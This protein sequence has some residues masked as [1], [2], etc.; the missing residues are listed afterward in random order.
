MTRPLKL[1]FLAA[2]LMTACGLRLPPVHSTQPTAIHGTLYGSANEGST[3]DLLP[4][5]NAPLSPTNPSLASAPL[6]PD[7]SFVLTLPSPTTLAVYLSAPGEVAGALRLPL[8]CDRALTT[9]PTD[10]RVYSVGALVNGQTSITT[11]KASTPFLIEEMLWLYASKAARIEG[12]VSCQQNWSGVTQVTMV[13]ADLLLAVGWN[14]VSV[15]AEQVVP[16]VDAK[17]VVNAT[18]TTRDDQ[19]TLWFP[20]GTVQSGD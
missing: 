16:T 7:G 15:R 1:L 18:F 5:S 6:R 12:T 11:S 17:T 2:G 14:L 19:P 4:N 9:T 3:V 8:N 20:S 13:V 10:V